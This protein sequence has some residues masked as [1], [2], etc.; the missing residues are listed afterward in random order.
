[1]RAANG[2]SVVALTLTSMVLLDGSAAAATDPYGVYLI[3]EAAA[4]EP[5]GAGFPPDYCARPAVFGRTPE[6]AGRKAVLANNA[7]TTMECSKVCRNP[8]QF[9]GATS[10]TYTVQSLC[11]ELKHTHSVTAVENPKNLA[12]PSCGLG[13]GN[14]ISVGTGNKYLEEV[15]FVAGGN[16]PL[17]F[18]RSYNSRGFGFNRI[19]QR[20]TSSYSQRFIFTPGTI[21]AHRPDGRILIFV[22]Q[23]GSSV[24]DPDVHARVDPFV[25]PVGETIGWIYTGPN[26]AVQTYDPDGRLL[27]I[28]HENGRVENLTY[29]DGKLVR[30]EDDIGTFLEFGYDVSGRI[31]EMR[32]QGGRVWHFHYDTKGDL[33]AVDNPDGTP[34]RYHYNEPSLTSGANLQHALTGV[35]DERNERFAT[36]EYYPDGRA[37]ASYHAGNADRVEVAYDDTSGVNT[38][39]DSRQGIRIYSVETILGRA[40][41]L[42]LDGAACESCG[43]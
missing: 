38:V 14:P 21:T 11:T 20:W 25:D 33:I 1:M 12:N 17:E 26:G 4:D 39:T 7:I 16:S 6:D 35:T 32:A 9:L 42:Q 8:T 18:R 5:H 36:Y 19:G 10:T 15:D 29:S 22:D 37:K 43:L 2:R 24:G 13:A 30:V 3:P 31:L 28:R 40:L 34:R 41:P 23:G 27:D